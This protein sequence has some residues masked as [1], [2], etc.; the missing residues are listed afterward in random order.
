MAIVLRS[1]NFLSSFNCIPS[2]SCRRGLIRANIN[3]RNNQTYKISLPRLQRKARLV[4]E[5]ELISV[6]STSSSSIEKQLSPS[7]RSDPLVIEKL[8]AIKE[9]IADRVEM[10]RNIGEQ[11]S[12]WNSMLLTSI[13]GITLAAA[14]L[15]GLAA[16]NGDSVLGLKMSSTLMYLAAT[17]MLAI[18]NQIQPSQLAEEQRNAARL[19]QDLYNQVETTLSIGHPLAIDVKEAMD[20]VL[21]LD[22]AYPLPLLGVMLEK[23]P[24][25]VEPAVWWPQQRRRQPN[26]GNEWNGW[27]GK[28]EEEM[29]EIKGVLGRKDQE[30]YIRLGGKALKLNKFLAMSGPLLT[31]L[32]AVGSAF[33]GHSPH[34]SWAAMLGIVG[35]ALASVVNTIEHGGQVGMVFEMYRSNAGFFQYMQESIES[36]LTETETERRD[37]GEVFELKLALKLGRSLSDLRNLAADS[38]S[39]G[40]EIDEFASKLF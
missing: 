11:R 36:N 24:S 1:S 17:G 40:E 2:I 37:N 18:M 15:T 28:L 20:K 6:L 33:A 27:N 26:H 14:I 13:N 9:A 7:R 5:E 10:H 35:G 8:Y 23:F 22:K 3:I 38:L 16:S 21:A 30:E 25:S 19:F 12:Q 34:G 32:A 4:Q 31:G 29:K 39:K